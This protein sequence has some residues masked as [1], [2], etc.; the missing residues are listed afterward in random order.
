MFT[1]RWV[2]VVM[3]IVRMRKVWFVLYLRVVRH[4]T[5][6]GAPVLLISIGE[7]IHPR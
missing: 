6:S 1:T 5:T 4:V 7:D 2:V 3:V